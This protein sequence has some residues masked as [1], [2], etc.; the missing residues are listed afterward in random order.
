MQ[1]TLEEIMRR[2]NVV[3][4][5]YC[6][7]DDKLSDLIHFMFN[8]EICLNVALSDDQINEIVK[9]IIGGTKCVEEEKEDFD[10][11]VDDIR[12]SNAIRSTE[13][14]VY[15]SAL[16]NMGLRQTITTYN[17]RVRSK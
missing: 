12:K 17:H 10:A 7:L 14:G 13:P 8:N 5:L 1:K 9:R 16:M 2:F 11:S 6:E 4:D 15:L 3:Q